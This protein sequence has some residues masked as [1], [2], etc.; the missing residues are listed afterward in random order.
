MVGYS[1]KKVKERVKGINLRCNMKETS[2][3]AIFSNGKFSLVKGFY[4]D[5]FEY[6]TCCVECNAQEI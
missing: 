6:L 4:F 5:L 1:C 3:K 2:K